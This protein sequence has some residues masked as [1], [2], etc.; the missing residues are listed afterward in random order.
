MKKSNSFVLLA[1]LTV[2]A[3]FGY[4]EFNGVQVSKAVYQ[5]N[6]ES[7]IQDLHT[8]TYS[9][10]TFKF[11]EP[12]DKIVIQDTVSN[13]LAKTG[14]LRLIRFVESDAYGVK[15]QSFGGLIP[16]FGVKDGVLT[17]NF[18]QRYY[19]M[20]NDPLLIYA[21][22][23]TRISLSNLKNFKIVHSKLDSLILSVSN[24]SLNLDH[25]NTIQQLGVYETHGSE[26][27]VQVP[28]VEK[29][30][31]NLDSSQVNHLSLK[32]D[33]VEIHGDATSRAA[34]GAADWKGKMPQFGRIRYNSELG[35]IALSTSQVESIEGDPDQLFL[36]MRL[37][38]VAKLTQKLKP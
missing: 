15:L 16:A 34:L 33:W 37:Q 28:N 25:T 11:E 10:N 1:S 32:S 3:F 17:I 20:T 13:Q 27:T 23:F 24:S 12:F 8:D 26:L 31:Y 30:Y 7:S 14:D 21:P 22:D 36:T 29:A 6:K 9:Y 2:L 35:Y 18:N 38:D 5:E 19:G 4:A